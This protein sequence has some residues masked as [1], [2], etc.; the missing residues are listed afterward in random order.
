MISPLI[1]NCGEQPSVAASCQNA[2]F[3]RRILLVDD[4]P[5]VRTSL[6]YALESEGYMVLA[7]ATGEQAVEQSYTENVD[8]VLLDLQLPDESGWDVFEQITALT[9]FM[10][11]III[12]ARSD[13]YEQASSVGATAI[14]EKP[15]YLPLL[16]ST[17][18][19]VLE[20][21][22]TERVRRIIMHQ[23]LVLAGPV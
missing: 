14:M 8:L 22:A 20:E 21:S 7:A 17:I 10:P 4:D 5:G 1:Q 2:R 6:G 11:V 23:P 13:Q 9:P 18:Q 15:L 3:R 19:R 12:T 16:M